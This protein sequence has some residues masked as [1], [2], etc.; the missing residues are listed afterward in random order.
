LLFIA[1]FSY[2]AHKVRLH[3][4]AKK[5]SGVDNA[6]VEMKAQ[7]EP[8]LDPNAVPAAQA[9]H[10]QYHDNL[11]YAS[12]G[13][14]SQYPQAYEAPGHIPEQPPQYHAPQGQVPVSPELYGQPLP[15]QHEQYTSPQYQQPSPQPYQGTT[16]QQH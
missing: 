4:Q 2:L 1:S 14:Q 10:P 3:L 12:Q 7:S 16:Y 5:N 8:M 15:Q 11:Q 9:G 6:V 13:Y